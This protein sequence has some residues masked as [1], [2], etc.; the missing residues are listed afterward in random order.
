MRSA[1]ASLLRRSTKKGA[2]AARALATGAKV[3]S[4]AVKD[5][6]LT[7]VRASDIVVRAPFAVARAI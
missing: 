1:G 3:K 7:T 4:T 2:S 6:Q 5:E